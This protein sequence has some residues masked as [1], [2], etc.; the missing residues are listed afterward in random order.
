MM[1][2]AMWWTIVAV[3]AGLE[4]ALPPLSAQDL[5]APCV[6]LVT[7]EEVRSLGRKEV[8]TRVSHD[9]PGMSL[10][11]WG[12][13]GGSF[14]I[15]LQTAEWFKFESS[16]GPRESFDLRRHGYDA[17]VGTDPVSGIGLE[18]RIT[19]HERL[20]VLLVRREKDVISV[21]CDC[22]REQTIAIAKLAVARGK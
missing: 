16:A 17:T 14:V 9:Q 1:T 7:V 5:R 13:E 18:A 22:S 10:C 11:G 12:P 8:L 15:T 3:V 20:P 21:M 4:Q 2:L 6:G 19:R